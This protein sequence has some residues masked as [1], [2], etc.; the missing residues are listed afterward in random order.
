MLVF[1]S[2][3]FRA[4]YSSTLEESTTNVSELDDEEPEIYSLFV[5]W[6]YFKDL[7]EDFTADEDEEDN[8]RKA[9]RL[10]R[11]WTVADRRQIPRLQDDV[12]RLLERYV[13]NLRHAACI[14]LVYENTPPGSQLRAF[15]VEL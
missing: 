12:M 13:A 2:A 3:Y 15:I 14:P 5:H 9:M 11:L 7:S 4:A 6:I 1:Y 8:R 10:L